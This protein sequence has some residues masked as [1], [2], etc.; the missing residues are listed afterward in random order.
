MRRTFIFIIL[1]SLFGQYLLGQKSTVS[2]DSISMFYNEF[3]IEAKKKIDLW[4][5]DLYG[6]ILLI[7]SKT[8]AVFANEP[9]ES[10][11]LKA[12]GNIYT[13]VLPDK[14]NIANTA[15]NWNGKRWAMMMLPLP[16]NKYDRI[17][18]LAHESFHR[19]QPS[20]GFELNNIENN[21]LDQK[22][23]RVYLRLELEA[24]KRALTAVSEKELKKHLTN[25]LAFRK[26]R[27]NLYN[28]SDVSENFL[29]LNEGIAEFTGVIVS[30]RSKE[31]TI[32]SLSN[33]IDGFIDNPTFVRSFAY[34][35][36][37]VY[38]Y[39][40]Y[41]KDKS[42]NKKITGKTNLTNYFI[43]AFNIEIANDFKDAVEKLVNDYNG[44]VIIEEETKREERIK[45]LIAEYKSKFIDQP[46]FEI[47]FEKMNV[48]FDPRNII[49]IEDKGTVYPN[50]RVT[51]KWGIL[52]VEKGALMSPNWDKIS[53]S[54]PVSIDGEKIEGDGWILE[55]TDGYG[56]KKNET[57]GIYVLIK[58]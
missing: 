49:P 24:L 10:G 51:D 2:V 32:S 33:G 45:N 38:G 17:G 29:E 43:K 25:A 37:P 22:E 18:L 48:S 57:N 5:K 8:K 36:V 3:K 21:H 9:D 34:H 47:K 4:N 50:I 39:L 16:K 20:L 13:G 35:T 31:Q 44:S 53:I 14:I 42:W 19:I 56:I 40:L 27:H 30:G 52:T 7:D 54:N 26:Y 11:I 23:G 46:H 1:F 28:G 12:D 55:L 15:I 6:P 58:K 41:K